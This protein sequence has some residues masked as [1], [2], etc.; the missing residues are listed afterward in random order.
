MTIKNSIEQAQ[1]A[2]AKAQ[3]PVQ[4]KL[5]KI[6]HPYAF[7]WASYQALTEGMNMFAKRRLQF[8]YISYQHWLNPGDMDVATYESLLMEAVDA[9]PKMRDDLAKIAFKR[10]VTHS[11]E[12]ASAIKRC[13]EY[14][15]EATRG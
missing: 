1:K 15:R 10:I 5:D 8:E 3:N 13:A 7:D 14:A 6:V 9:D 2:A 11:V 12:A 4:H